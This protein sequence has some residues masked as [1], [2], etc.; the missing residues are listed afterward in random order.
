MSSAV[1]PRSEECNAIA[2]LRE[3]VRAL[4]RTHWSSW[5]TT[6]KF[7]RELES[8]REFLK[9]YDERNPDV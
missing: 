9:G 6:A 4:D 3:L 5:Q 8:A 1:V 2:E 7:D